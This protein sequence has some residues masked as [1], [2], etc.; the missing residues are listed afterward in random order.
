MIDRNKVYNT[1]IEFEK[2]IFPN[3]YKK[4]LKHLEEMDKGTYEERIKKIMYD[5]CLKERF[6]QILR[7]IH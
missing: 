1:Y 4:R 6:R 2:Y 5:K 3:S 7:E